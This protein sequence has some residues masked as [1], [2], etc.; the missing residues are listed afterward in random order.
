[1]RDVDSGEWVREQGQQGELYLASSCV[2]PGYYAHADGVVIADEKAVTKFPRATPELGLNEASVPDGATLFQTGDLVAWQDDG[3]LDHLGRVDDQVK[4][5][6]VRT[7]LGDITAATLKCAGVDAALAVA[8]KD[9]NGETRVVVAVSPR[10]NHDELMAELAT[11]LPP[12]YM[13]SS[14]LS[15][16]DLPKL[17]NGKVDQALQALAA[18]QLSESG[19]PIRSAACLPAREAA[20][21]CPAGTYLCLHLS[22][23]AI[24]FFLMAH[25]KIFRNYFYEDNLHY[26]PG[27]TT[28]RH[29][30]GHLARLRNGSLPCHVARLLRLRLRRP[31]RNAAEVVGRLSQALAHGL[32]HLRRR[33]PVRRI[34]QS[35][36]GG[37]AAHLPCGALAAPPALRRHPGGARVG[38]GRRRRRHRLCRKCRL[39]AVGPLQDRRREASAVRSRITPLCGRSILEHIYTDGVS[40]QTFCRGSAPTLSR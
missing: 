24:L 20:P 1:M 13:P 9:I 14:C 21:F 31:G 35:V 5:N 34:R 7:E 33:E 40:L 26:M 38:V 10:L 2:V 28:G 27:T 39:S 32:R 19:P 37:A 6:G 12:V 29:S 23:L 8:T 22:F 16:D 3:E 25:V 15:L 36:A 17:A 18:E 4:V 30:S 11:H